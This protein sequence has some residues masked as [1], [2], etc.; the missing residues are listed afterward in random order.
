MV[1]P[2]PRRRAERRSPLHLST[3]TSNTSELHLCVKRPTVKQ[4]DNWTNA[5]SDPAGTSQLSEPAAAL[6][7]G[8]DIRATCHWWCMSEKISFAPS[9]TQTAVREQSRWRSFA[10][11]SE[12]PNNPNLNR[13]FYQREAL[14]RVSLNSS[15]SDT[16]FTFIFFSP[17]FKID[18]P[19]VQQEPCEVFNPWLAMFVMWS[20]HSSGD[21][22]C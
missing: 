9:Q 14:F 8:N 17:Y 16:V 5:G 3:D 11:K 15:R 20:K 10:M 21:C 19:P 7:A 6:A 1:H 2:K 13:N 22:W 12:P 4:L 18:C